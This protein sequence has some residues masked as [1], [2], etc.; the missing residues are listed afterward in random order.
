MAKTK[1]ATR[2]HKTP[3]ESVDQ[4]RPDAPESGSALPENEIDRKRYSQF[5]VDYSSAHIG[6]AIRELREWKRIKRT[7]LARKT[8]I[9]ESYLAMIEGGFYDQGK[10][11]ISV[12]ILN[13][14]AYALKVPT[15][16][17]VVM[18][19]PQNDKGGQ[20]GLQISNLFD[21]TKALIAEAVKLDD[22]VVECFNSEKSP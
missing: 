14:I 9:S 4:L 18:A 6:K 22:V 8:K 20:R 7:T 13:R 21:K 3:R 11:S 16:W 15:V 10:R 17:I 19:Y 2:R 1:D 5:S 12:D